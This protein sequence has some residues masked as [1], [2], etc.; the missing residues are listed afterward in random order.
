M[1]YFTRALPL[2]TN[3]PKGR[4]C[5]HLHESAFTFIGQLVDKR[6]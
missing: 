4:G 6:L 5:S 1:K 3:E 2:E